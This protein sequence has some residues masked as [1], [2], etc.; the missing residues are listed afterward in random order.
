MFL[1][2]ASSCLLYQDYWLKPLQKTLAYAQALQYWAEKAN[3][4]VPSEPHHLAM[5]IHELRWCMRRYMAFSDHDV[6][7]GLPHGLPEAEVEETTQTNPIKPLVG[8]SPAVLA[9]APSVPENVSAAL[10]ATPATSEE[11]LVAL[12]TISTALAD[13]SADPPSPSETNGNAR[14][15]TEPEYLKWIKVHLSHMVASVR[16]IPCNPGDLR[17]CHCNCSSSQQ[18]ELG[19]SWRKNSRPSD[20]LPAQPCLEDPQSWHPKRRKTQKPNQRCCLQDSKR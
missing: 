18:K 19:A 20:F 2:D 12:V 4:P 16:S 5:S 15:L 3:L 10:I 13:E 7:E 9:I 8:D 17:W 1:S 14:G 11:E 6:F